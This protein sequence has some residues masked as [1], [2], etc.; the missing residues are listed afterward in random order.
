MARRGAAVAGDRFG[1]SNLNRQDIEFANRFA[2]ACPPVGRA[3][4]TG[5][6]RVEARHLG[7]TELACSA[8]DGH[9]AAPILSAMKHTAGAVVA[10]AL[11]VGGASARADRYETTITVRPTAVVARV[12]EVGVDQPAQ[13]RGGGASGGLSVGVRNWLDLGGEV[14]V[15]ALAPSRYAS[16]VVPVGGNP[17]QG[18][19]TRTSRMAQLRAVATLRFG[20]GWVPTIQ[21]GLGAGARQRT[22]ARLEAMTPQGTSTF[23]PDDGGAAIAFDLVAAARVGLDYRITRRWTI[24]VS[25]GGTECLGLGAPDL[26]LADATLAVAYTWYPRR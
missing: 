2:A 4:L 6:S 25:I 7:L 10:I 26:Q 14:A 17:Q 23:T 18:E 21:L 22:A 12:G 13:T 3:A 11:A 8:G 20:V 15:T 9:R 1:L 24:G 5:D 16:A 19:L